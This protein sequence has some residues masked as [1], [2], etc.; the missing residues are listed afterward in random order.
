MNV[1][2]ISTCTRHTNYYYQ[3][4]FDNFKNRNIKATENHLSLVQGRKSSYL[5]NRTKGYMKFNRSLDVGVGI[6]VQSLICHRKDL[7]AHILKYPLEN[8]SV[9]KINQA[10]KM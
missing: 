6:P 3:Y 1:P 2:K 10:I 8:M 7:H 4:P 9:V 5:Y